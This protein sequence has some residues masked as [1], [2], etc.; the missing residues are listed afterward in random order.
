MSEEATVS[1]ANEERV[2]TDYLLGGLD[3]TTRDQILDRLAEDPD[4]YERMA[5]LDDDLILRWHRGGL[6]PEQRA[7]FAVSYATPA[8]RARVEEAL[9][10]LRAAE[11]SRAVPRKS[12][13]F[14]SHLRAWILT[15]GSLPRYAFVA[16]AVL[17]AGL[18]LWQRNSGILSPGASTLTATLG[19]QGERGAP[20]ASFDRLEVASTH[21]R[22]ELTV[23]GLT[24]P[25]GA[26][27]SAELQ[28]R[29][30]GARL[31]VTPPV[32]TRS[33][34]A[35]DATVIVD[36]PLLVPG[37]YVLTLRVAGS[38]DGETVAT[39]SFRVARRQ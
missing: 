11:A 18:F 3:A 13:G 4:Y 23:R 5:A 31:P 28:A 7:S 34:G 1:D 16:S 2:M 20:R 19:A 15:S 27:L 32:M 38:P 21:T 25:E 8:R 24:V 17:V 37:D 9:N 33:N 14:L 35:T 36:A 10:V 22:V 12:P 30:G 39:Q 29:D 26:G 6:T